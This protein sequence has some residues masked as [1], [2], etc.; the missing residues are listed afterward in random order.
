INK[1]PRM[2]AEQ[3]AREEKLKSLMGARRRGIDLAQAEAVRESYLEEG[4]RLPLV[5]TP[6]KEGV[7]LVAWAKDNLA[8]IDRELLRHGAVLFRGFGLRE[9]DAFERFAQAVTPDLVD[10]V[11]GS[12]PRIMLGEKVYT[13]TEYPPEFFVSLHNELSYAHRW[14]SRLFFFCL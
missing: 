10:Y 3:R 12:S 11:E 4:G 13:S 6:T 5:L 9:V 2:D 1:E 8:R 14:P 7:D